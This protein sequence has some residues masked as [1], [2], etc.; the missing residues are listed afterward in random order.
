MSRKYYV[1]KNPDCNGKNIEWNEITSKQ[2]KELVKNPENVSRRFIKFNNDICH[3]ADVIILECTESQYKD[4]RVDSN[5]VDYL[6]RCR[7]NQIELSFDT[8][9]GMTELFLNEIIADYSVD[10]EADAIES[11]LLERLTQAIEC[12]TNEEKRQLA[13]FFFCDESEREIAR[14]NGIPQ[15]T[16]NNR[17]KAI[18]KKLKKIMAQ[19]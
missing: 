7:K 9:Y 15:K 8:A 12:L 18:I 16:M 2:F 4:W 6:K 19:I 11:Y 1:W 13:L 5:R 14:R 17:K 10:V 3:D